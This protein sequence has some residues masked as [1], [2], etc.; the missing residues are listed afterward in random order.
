MPD[1]L[2]PKLP[3]IPSLFTPEDA[4]RKV[5]LEAQR[6]EFAKIYQNKFSPQAWQ[7]TTEAEKG[8][9]QAIGSDNV[10]SGVVRALT[11]DDWGFDYG[12]TP[13]EAQQFGINLE[14]EIAELRRKERVSGMLE[15]INN[16]MMLAAQSGN[17]ISV[18]DL[19]KRFP[20]IKNFNATEQQIVT[21]SAKILSGATQEEIDAGLTDQEITNSS[22]DSYY[23]NEGKKVQPSVILSTV[24]FSKDQDEINNALRAAY[25]PKEKEEEETTLNPDELQ[26]KHE[27]IA[28]KN[29][30]VLTMVDDETGM[31]FDATLRE[32]NY[33]IVNGEPVG[34][35]N[36]DRGTVSP[37]SIRGISLE[38]DDAILKENENLI[39]YFGKWLMS[40]LPSIG[41]SAT[42][43]FLNTLPSEELRKAASRT[44]GEKAL[45]SGIPIIALI[46][47]IF[48]DMSEK[49]LPE[50]KVFYDN[51]IKYLT[52]K[53][54]E[55]QIQYD[56][57][58]AKHP[59]L[60]LTPNEKYNS[61]SSNPEV[62]T[63][64]YFYT[65]Q[66]ATNAPQIVLGIGT[67]IGTLL[68]TKNVMAASVASSAFITPIQVQ[69]NYEDAI[70]SG[71]TEE[72]A[73]Q[74]AVSTGIVQF[75]IEALLTRASA[76]IFNPT[77]SKLIKSITSKEVIKAYSAKGLLGEAAKDVFK[78]S[79]V[80]GAEEALQQGVQNAGIR[81]IDESR[82]LLENV[83]DS[84][85]VGAIVSSPM[86][87]SGSVTNTYARM[88]SKLKT[89]IKQEIDTISEKL[90][91]EGMESNQAEA[92]AV[93]RVM[94]TEKGEAAI[95]KANNDIVKDVPEHKDMGKTYQR[96]TQEYESIKTDVKRF[97]DKYAAQIIIVQKAKEK[98]DPKLAQEE[99][100]LNQIKSSLDWLTERGT[101]I[102]EAQENIRKYQSH[103]D[104]EISIVNKT[105]RNTGAVGARAITPAY[106]E[107]TS[108]LSDS[109]LDYGAGKD[110]AHTL[111]LRNS[112]F[113]VTAY[114]IGSNILEG[115]HDTQALNKKYD[116]V[117]ASN[118]I[119]TSPSLS[120]L[121]STLREIKSVTKTRA[122]FNYPES[123]RK[124]GLSVEDM[125]SIIKEYFPS[126]HRVGGTKNAPLWE[127]IIA[128]ESPDYNK[129]LPI[130]D[131]L[132]KLEEEK[133]S[134][135][136]QKIYD[137]YKSYLERKWAW[138]Q[139][140]EDWAYQQMSDA[141]EGIEG[142]PIP[143]PEPPEPVL[144]PYTSIYAREGI[145]LNEIE[146]SQNIL[147]QGELRWQILDTINKLPIDIALNIRK[148]SVNPEYFV[149][150]NKTN[151]DAVGRFSISDQEIIFKNMETARDPNAIIHEVAHSIV[152]ETYLQTGKGSIFS[153]DLSQALQHTDTYILD[154]L[155]IDKTGSDVG[156]SQM[157]AGEMHKFLENQGVLMVHF[158]QSPKILQDWSPAIH[159]VYVK[160]FP[161]K[162]DVNEAVDN[163]ILGDFSYTP[164]NA[165]HVPNNNQFRPNI[166]H[167]PLAETRLHEASH[168]NAALNLNKNIA[169]K[170]RTPVAAAMKLR[171]AMKYYNGLTQRLSSSTGQ[172]FKDIQK[173]Y[174]ALADK[175]HIKK[176]TLL[177]TKWYDLNLYD[178]R[179]IANAIAPDKSIKIPHFGFTRNI[180]VDSEYAFQFYEE[181]SGLPFYA[182]YRRF[183]TAASI[184]ES[185]KDRVV[186]RIV[187][188][189]NYKGIINNPEALTRVELEINS[190]NPE[191]N[192]TSDPAITIEER[193]LADEIM[194]IYK[195]YEPFVRFIR[196]MRTK[197]D[198]ESF[199]KEFPDAV[200]DGKEDQLIE[201]L[202]LVDLCESVQNF[203]PLWKYLSRP[204]V[205][206]GVIKSGYD[207]QLISYPNLKT[208]KSQP[209]SLRGGGRVVGR[210]SVGF[211][212]S[213]K[214]VVRRL[215]TYMDQIE[216][217][218]RLA[219]DVTSFAEMW[220]VVGSKFENM[221][222]IERELSDYF[223]TVQ[224]IP[225]N[226]GMGM[227]ALEAVQRQSTRVIFFN[228]KMWLRNFM[229]I[230]VTTTN[231]TELLRA[232]SLPEY[233]RALSKSY[234]DTCVSEIGGLRR[235]YLLQATR[236]ESAIAKT[237][238]GRFINWIGYQAD[239]MNMYGLTDN[240]PRYAQFRAALNK[241]QRA[242]KEYADNSNVDQ[243]LKDSGAIDLRTTEQ[244]YVLS[245]YLARGNETFDMG[246]EG[247]HDIKGYDM[248]ALYIAQRS[249]DVSFYKYA[250]DQRSFGEMGMGKSLL[251][252]LTFPRGYA[253]RQLFN[254]E[255]L[256]E[257]FKQET[258][259]IYE[260]DIEWSPIVRN[261]LKEIS[262]LIVGTFFA[263]WLWGIITGEDRN[264]YEPFSIFGA[265]QIGGLVFGIPM[266]MFEAG[267]HFIL[268][269]NPLNSA[270]ERKA[271]AD[272]FISTTPTRFA[273]SELFFYRIFM[274]YVDLFAGVKNAD[275]YVV[276][277]I[278]DFLD[279]EY[280]ARDPDKVDRNTLDV[281]RKL[282]ISTDVTLTEAEEVRTK[283]DEDVKLLGTP[284]VIG[285]YYTLKEYGSDLNTHF[286]KKSNDTLKEA[287]KDNPLGLFYL[288]CRD[289]WKELIAM[290]ATTRERI[291]QLA[292]KMEQT[293]S[294]T[295]KARIQSQIDAA[296]KLIGT[297]K[298]SDAE[299]LAIV[300]YRLS[301]PE[302]E[303]K[304]L[305]WGKYSTTVYAKGTAQAN[306]VMRLITQW[307]DMYDITPAMKAGYSPKKK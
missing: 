77:L 222:D 39:G 302:L 60:D 131:I 145:D 128:K 73:K 72:Q 146:F 172:A 275:M 81:L 129:F 210:Q 257:A 236:G 105:S 295:E 203:D 120:F 267:G 177:T 185:V 78:E 144:P 234:F 238:V 280:E 26:V 230:M 241:A 162:K 286:G 265:T 168:V 76:L 84:F 87:A 18:N 40:T 67:F 117:Y 195:Y 215:F 297:D 193:S 218:W 239:Y 24:A 20:E 160:H 156:S 259:R 229:Q 181:S 68:A 53:S 228:P 301:H 291:K 217:Q 61:P 152:F 44:A 52:E 174:S 205:D 82:S 276:K 41:Q 211:K 278:R 260:G 107:Q 5:E 54:K 240:V 201:A 90:R 79:F 197:K 141:V 113:N 66:L 34:Y 186:K 38:T 189:P 212:A 196:V 252:L 208:S 9:R 88:K 33:V 104:E 97:S 298:E 96:I 249:S 237:P 28:K 232:N 13:E 283:L 43:Y 45:E 32:D 220:D 266:D 49:V 109:I 251:N 256:S 288:D 51:A 142:K 106:V 268:A 281:M 36:K 246:A 58:K 277:K 127:V 80:E 216:I 101:V 199:K 244:N 176:S 225:F 304:L 188:D 2:M 166:T 143:E 178:Q 159:D 35:Y 164:N 284:N 151:P 111:R 8:I 59:E 285:D 194:A 138:K 183:Q 99:A 292:A 209:D 114:D 282:M 136:F 224:H 86:A 248:A 202:G 235:D 98:N 219:P 264:S 191:F 258:S 63:D 75:G 274:D 133:K 273:D 69:G 300:K 116:T 103:P 135:E 182:F 270:E 22:L 112:G 70:A 42:E 150:Y 161:R 148:I 140:H 263:G 17:P 137:E 165:R 121:R 46:K 100:K 89:E 27:Q 299:K 303:A 122:V 293:S 29:G 30:S 110:A 3:V 243:W 272:R 14:R 198:L 227:R 294:V 55:R 115:V 92:I 71:A 118:V 290:P 6:K 255:A 214:D 10:P 64:P 154:Q 200:K 223:Q 155:G 47:S 125:E 94:E 102:T 242:T 206:W 11:P 139:A 1:D 170:I 132:Q 305:F 221:N 247:L 213:D 163:E 175:T 23:A 173:E 289:D 65:Y 158:I 19:L 93:S 4:K 108:K 7:Q 37:I 233:Y 231:K 157:T 130:T 187:T 253:Q 25:P 123:P 91:K 287:L 190:R 50:N 167:I 95:N 207:P 180:L 250:R 261:K 262:S 179:I 85:I 56:D 307:N 153:L 271:A 16:D 149:E 226:T 119:N 83:P 15:T 171:I 21:D 269:V 184:S 192:L 134:P 31:T 124:L 204:D 57:F 169:S 254:L 279:K 74:I 12:S 245:N 48:P 147:D 306:S 296:K 62:Y 126:I